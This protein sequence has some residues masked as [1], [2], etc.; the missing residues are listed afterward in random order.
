MKKQITSFLISLL[1]VI[2]AINSVFL[3]EIYK[4]ENLKNFFYKGEE[5]PNDYTEKEKIHMQEVKD[6]SFVSLKLGLFFLFVIILLKPDKK[7]LETSGF[8]SLLFVGLFI[9]FAIFFQTFF[10]YFHILSFDSTNWLLPPDSKLIKD[11]PLEYFRNM[12][13]LITGIIAIISIIL[14]NSKKIKESWIQ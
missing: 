14:I 13:L 1:I 5:L 9:F 2:L 12:F 8:L 4:D 3:V 6:L 11:Y 7:V 10:H